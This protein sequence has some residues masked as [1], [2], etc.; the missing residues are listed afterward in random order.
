MQAETEAEVR[1]ALLP[2]VAGGRDLALDAAHAEAAGDHDAVE[3]VQPPFG[4]QALGVVG[5]DP[6][7]LDLRAA[8]IAAVLQRLD[9]RQ[10]GVGQVDVLADEADA[11][12]LVGRRTRS[13][14]AAHSVR[15]GS[16]SSRC[17]TRHT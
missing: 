10:V 14:S 4:E 3:A 13:T 8:R 12:G 16:W 6:V 5:G 7:D 1:D 2:R 9:D 15:S 17:S 11:H